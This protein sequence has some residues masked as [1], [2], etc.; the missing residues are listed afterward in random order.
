[1]LVPS[2]LNPVDL[3]MRRVPELR[4]YVAHEDMVLPYAVFG[5]TVGLLKEE[6]V[7]EDVVRRVFD[8][9]NDLIERRIPE[10]ENLV[11]VG[12][13]EAVAD[14]DRL[15]RLAMA[16]LGTRARSLLRRVD[17]A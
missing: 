15:R 17:T 1:M 3:L 10:L 16:Q 5:I 13:L 14:D 4:K 7:G 2:P 11:Q 8:V 12:A 6:A 9:F